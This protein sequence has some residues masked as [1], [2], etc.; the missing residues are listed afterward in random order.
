[1]E[2][3]RTVLKSDFAIESIVSLHYFEFAR[4]YIFEGESHD[5]WEFVYADTGEVEVM[6]DTDGYRLKQGDVIFHRP[7]E[8]HNLW[9]NGRIAPNL[10]VISFCCHSPAMAF[11]EKKIFHVADAERQLLTRIVQEA[12]QTFASPLNV[13]SLR[14]LEPREKAPLGGE[15]LI[16]MMLEA[17]LILLMRRNTQVKSV[18]RLSSAVR[19]R[20]D[21]NI[22][23]KVTRYLSAHICGSLT[24]EDVC[25]AL[26]MSRTNLKTIFKS[27]TGQS[28]MEYY[29]GLKIEE[30]KRLIRET[31]LNFTQIADKLGYSS[32]HYFS[33]QFKN[34]TGTT[35]SQY[36]CSAK[37]FL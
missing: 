18:A 16:R 29:R 30:A 25:D 4:D 34:V 8:F 11:F 1:M 27:A 13:S 32:I 6:A 36:S 23:R 10:I 2:Y 3:I 15:Q 21:G 33:R 7:N 22:A 12:K 9:A 28:V 35:P 26:H 20:S 37:L 17:F 5:F 14:K 24:F 19:E 31:D